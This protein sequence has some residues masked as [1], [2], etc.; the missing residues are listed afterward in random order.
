MLLFCVQNFT[1][2]V[3]KEDSHGEDEHGQIKKISNTSITRPALGLAWSAIPNKRLFLQRGKRG[4]GN[5]I[6]SCT[7][8]KLTHVIIS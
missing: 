1:V 6:Y 8:D 7:L 2:N 5:D 3:S 4:S